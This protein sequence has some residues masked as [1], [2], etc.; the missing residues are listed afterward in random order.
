MSRLNRSVLQFL[1]NR[2][3]RKP[4]LALITRTGTSGSVHCLCPPHP[5]SHFSS[6]GFTYYIMVDTSNFYKPE[7]AIYY[8]PKV[9]RRV[10]IVTGGNS[11]IGWYTVLHLYLHGYVVYVAGRTESKV[12]KAIED[13]EAEAHK[14]RE[15]Y[16][17]EEKR[18]RFV[19]SL[20]YIHFDCTNLKSV[21]DC[22]QKFKAQ[23]PK[24]HIL[25]NNAGIMAVPY[26]VTGDG[27]EIQYQV[28]FVAPFLFTSELLPALE[29]ATVDQKPRVVCLS[30][31]G[32]NAAHKYFHPSDTINKFPNFYFT[33][34]RY[35]NAKAAE[36]EF[37]TKLA[38]QYPQF[39]AFSVHPGL[40]VDTE[41]GN[42]WKNLPVL[43]Y[44]FSG[45]FKVTG[46][47]LGIT[48]DQGSYASLRAAL[49]PTLL[50]KSGA[51]LDQGGP[52]GVP[53]KV[54]TNRANIDA[55]WTENIKL[56]KEKG[57]TVNY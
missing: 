29:L 6:Q 23:E 18:E 2:I 35:G 46:S 49:D 42:W 53:S 55:T 40:I 21:V 19:G 14:R 39:E 43:G 12:T 15:A 47:L 3:S 5:T 25:I 44:A 41:L 56:L 13:I 27:Y 32:H 22:A 31:L 24:L 45:L 48:P 34:V 9:D 30:S 54:V 10:A 38:E 33:W 37:T 20:T 1:N 8:N 28:N 57:Y 50:D 51:Y 16:S 36:I 4:G 26:E 11:G 17:E 52:I 7:L